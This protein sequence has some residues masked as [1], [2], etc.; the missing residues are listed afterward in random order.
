MATRLPGSPDCDVGSAAATAVDRVD[1]EGHYADTAALARHE[2]T[3][4]ALEDAAMRDR[5]VNW[6]RQFFGSAWAK[7]DL[8]KPGTFRL[9]PPDIRLSA[10]RTDYRAMRPMY[11]SE[12]PSFDDVLSVLADLE[13]RI[14]VGG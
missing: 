3:G 13:E 7:Y 2:I 14:N 10:L 8:A 4:R 11:L 9:I 1:G 6:I 12:P 5:V